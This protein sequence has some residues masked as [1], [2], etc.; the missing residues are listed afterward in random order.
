MV[1]GRAARTSGGASSGQ[2]ANPRRRISL[3]VSGRGL[4]YQS[5]MSLVPPTTTYMARFR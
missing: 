4:G 3:A 2:T 5:S 1:G